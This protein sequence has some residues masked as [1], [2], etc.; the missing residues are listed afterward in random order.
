MA[1]KWSTLWHKSK[2]PHLSGK[3]VSLSLNW[4]SFVFWKGNTIERTIGV[5]MISYDVIIG[6]VLKMCATESTFKNH[7]TLCIDFVPKLY[8]KQI[9]QIIICELLQRYNLQPL[10]RQHQ[11]QQNSTLILIKKEFFILQLKPVINICLLLL[12]L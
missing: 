2:T 3:L 12:Y 4:D 7:K 10:Q 6:N 9:K 5:W 11:R 1:L 8:D